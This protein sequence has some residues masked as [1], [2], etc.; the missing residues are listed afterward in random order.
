MSPDRPASQAAFNDA[1]G[2]LVGGVNSPVR[3]HAAVGGEPVFIQSARGAWVTD[4]DGRRYVDYIGSYGPLIL[5][6]A[7]PAV[8]A[9]ASEALAGGSTFGAPTRRE[10][11]LARAVVAAVGSAERVRF[12]S[13]GTEAAMTAIRLA[14]GATG[15]D[16]IVKCAGCYHGHA[17]AML[18]AAGSGAMTLGVPSSP[19]V[20]AGA[21][22]DTAVIPY[23]DA[24]AAEAAIDA[25]T[26][27]ILV[28]PVAGNMGVV[29]P[30]PGYLQAL[31]ATCDRTGAMLVFDEVMTGFRLAYGGAQQRY[32]ITPDLTALGKVIGGG[33]PVGAVAGPEAILRHLAPA[34]PV[35]Q[36]GTLSGNPVAM[37]AGIATLQVLAEE[38]FYEQLEQRSAELETHLA[39]AAVG[40]GLARR[41]CIQRVGSMLSCFFRRAGE[42]TDAVSD[43]D[44]AAESGTAAFATFFHAMADA[45]VLL[46]PSPF[47]AMFVSAAHGPEELDHTRQAAE[48][49]FAA[50][51]QQG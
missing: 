13:S 35:Y 17:D 39:A 9:A 23:N 38:G 18:V 47:E 8:V 42:P 46:A 51:A 50:V 20:P 32:G 1:S 44:E 30:G 36:A 49:A 27:A 11:E 16:R 37:A 48:A 15:R 40:A 14:R 41:V 12:V 33:L 34:G 43:Y 6:H 10:T 29:P 3:A 2:V 26:A 5:G 28:E 22:A 7:H 21:T 31:R 25:Q 24:Q 4:L 19:G 45:G